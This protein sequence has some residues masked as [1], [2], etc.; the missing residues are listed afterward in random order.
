MIYGI[1]LD[2]W[3]EFAER[4]GGDYPKEME[5]N[6]R[7][8]LKGRGP[9]QTAMAILGFMPRSNRNKIH[10]KD[11]ESIAWTDYTKGAPGF[12]IVPALKFNYLEFPNLG[13]GR[14]N[15]EEQAFF[16]RGL[17]SAQDIL[18]QYVLEGIE[19]TTLL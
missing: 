5:D 6:I 17:M 7:I 16:E 1:D 9:K 15:M 4:I 8:A 19:A 11:S 3:N 12:K 2:R 13:I 18:F 14:K 10:A